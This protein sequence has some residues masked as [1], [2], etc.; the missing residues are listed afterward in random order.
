MEGT[1]SLDFR[2]SA[3][4]IKQSPVVHDSTAFYHFEYCFE[5]AKVCS[6]F[7]RDYFC[8]DNGLRHSIYFLFL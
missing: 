2:P 3:F 5:F 6:I 1:V 7:E 8:D 4:F